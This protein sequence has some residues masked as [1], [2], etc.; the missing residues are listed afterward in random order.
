VE[1][2]GVENLKT[3]RNKFGENALAMFLVGYQ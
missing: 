2:G 3:L 1:V